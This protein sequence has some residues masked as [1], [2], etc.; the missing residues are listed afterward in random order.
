MSV[1][2]EFCEISQLWP[3]ITYSDSIV[4]HSRNDQQRLNVASELCSADCDKMACPCQI[5]GYKY[6]MTFVVGI[7]N[8]LITVLTLQYGTQINVIY[9]FYNR[10]N[11]L[12]FFFANRT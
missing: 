4:N 8:H 1:I 12:N 5:E 9:L 11:V 3:N 6:S 10:P 2:N 7:V